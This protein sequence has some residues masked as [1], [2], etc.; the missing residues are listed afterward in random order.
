VR[1][2]ANPFSD[3]PAKEGE[4]GAY[5]FGTEYAIGK[6]GTP[7]KTYATSTGSMYKMSLPAYN[8]FIAAVK[9][10]GKKGVVPTGFKV[11]VNADKTDRTVP[12]FNDPRVNRERL[13]EL[14]KQHGKPVFSNKAQDLDQDITLEIPLDNGKTAKLTV[15]AQ[16]YINQLDKREEALR[17]V[18]ECMA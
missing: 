16:T 7:Y 10:A 13:D 15:N 14:V 11:S 6:D 4:Y 3:V 18:K 12:W 9:K 2:E 8:T 1:G 17:M 5:N